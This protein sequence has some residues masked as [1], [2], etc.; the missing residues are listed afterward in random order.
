VRVQFMRWDDMGYDNYDAAEVIHVRA[1][2]DAT[3]KITAFDYIAHSQEDAAQPPSAINT[4][5]VYLIP[6]RKVVGNVSPR[7]FMTAPLRSPMDRGPALATEQIVD[8]LAYATGTD[9]LEFRRQNMTGN[10]RWLEVLDAVAKAARWKPGRAA[11]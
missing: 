10:T 3:G 11:A 7:I 6:N 4:G 1:G 2:V 5:G 9:P 8:E